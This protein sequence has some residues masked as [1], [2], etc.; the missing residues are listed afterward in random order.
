VF[1]RERSGWPDYPVAPCRKNCV[2]GDLGCA[3]R[4][5]WS[6]RQWSGPLSRR[7]GL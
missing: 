6:R 2:P 7:T 3:A 5:F 1:W 4:W